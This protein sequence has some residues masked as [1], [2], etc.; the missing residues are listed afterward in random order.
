[1]F[2]KLWNKT[3]TKS[4]SDSQNVVKFDGGQELNVCVFSV[5]LTSTNSHLRCL[6]H[7]GLQV[8]GFAWHVP[9]K[10]LA[11]RGIIY[12]VRYCNMSVPLICG[13]F[14]ELPR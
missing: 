9:V 5:L 8:P 7:N 11:R 4:H 3:H 13:A 14:E 6:A 10:H 12:R 1:M 2:Q